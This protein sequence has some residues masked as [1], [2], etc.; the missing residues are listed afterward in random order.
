MKAVM[1]AAKWLSPGLFFCCCCCLLLNKQEGLRLSCLPLFL[2]NVSVFYLFTDL[3]KRVEATFFQRKK[4]NNCALKS[5]AK[6]YEVSKIRCYLWLPITA[7]H[8]WDWKRKFITAN[9]T[10]RLIKGIL[11]GSIIRVHLNQINLAQNVKDIRIN[12]L[13]LEYS[14]S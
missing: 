3:V 10:L 9:F 2:W 6:K 13:Y 4:K 5:F 7:E 8:V 11:R 14:R 12:M 1:E